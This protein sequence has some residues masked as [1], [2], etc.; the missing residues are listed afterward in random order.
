METRLQNGRKMERSLP[1]L[2]IE[3][4]NSYKSKRQFLALF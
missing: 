4:R 3:G 2:E 1:K